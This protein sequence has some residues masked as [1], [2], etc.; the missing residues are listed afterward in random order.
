MAEYYD[1]ETEEQVLGALLIDD[2][3][4]SKI[5]DILKP[6]DFARDK[7]QIVYKACL[8]LFNRSEITDERMV[9]HE[10][11]K[12]KQLDNIGGAAFLVGLVSRCTTGPAFIEHH[13][14]VIKQFAL[15]RALVRC[16]ATIESLADSEDIGKAYA[17][18]MGVLL[19][20]QE[21]TKDDYYMTPAQQAD[22]VLDRYTKFMNADTDPVIP[23]GISFL[24]PLGGMEGGD[25]VIIG[26]EPGEGKST[27]SY[28]IGG[29]IANGYGPV[30]FVS[31]EMSK[32]QITDRNIARLAGEPLMKI[33]TFHRD[34]RTRQEVYEK[35]CATAGPL[36][37]ERV[38]L[39]YPPE[40]TVPMIYARARKT[41]AEF[42]LA[43]V[44]VDYIQL[45]SDVNGARGETE[46]IK[47]IT[48]G[49]KIVARELNTP[50]IAVSSLTKAKEGTN[51]DRLYGSGILQYAPD[52]AFLI[53]RDKD[54]D[55]GEYLDTSKL[56]IIKQRQGGMKNKS[57]AVRL[58]K[59][60]QKF[61]EV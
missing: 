16:S 46:Q 9:A 38:H 13:A 48:K 45:L 47:N 35:L 23:F 40:C 28:Q 39:Y 2:K 6:A 60:T 17:D 36:S 11:T 10:L 44:I 58:N 52:W 42:G 61:E 12:E 55:T 8:S 22:F 24:N 20:A 33:R 25:F 56:I 3:A 32:G 37:T 27:L 50:V 31:A 18:A 43:A 14:G 19:T 1:L 49:L 30:L 51:L 54:K 41:Q 59:I 34:P 15:R 4:I 21:H 53:L 26:G 7:H 5:A 29:H 57:Q